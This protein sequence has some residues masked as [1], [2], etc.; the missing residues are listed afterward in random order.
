MGDPTAIALLDGPEPPDSVR[1][2]LEWADRLA[3]TRTVGPH[4]ALN[5]F[6]DEMIRA[7]AENMDLRPLPHEIDAL[8][9]LDLLMRFPDA[10]EED[11]S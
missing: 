11:E 8:L 4:G 7:W 1:Y 10:G 9:T 3:S 2:L 5:G 6:T